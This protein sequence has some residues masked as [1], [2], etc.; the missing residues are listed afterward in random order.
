MAINVLFGGQAF[1]TPVSDS[2]YSPCVDFYQYVNG[3]LKEAS[4]D[5]TGALKEIKKKTKERLTALFEEARTGRHT[6][7]DTT[8]LLLGRFYSSCMNAVRDASDSAKRAEACQAM[9]NNLLGE[10]VGRMYVSKT[11]PPESKKRAFIMVNNIKA[12]MRKRLERVAW[13]SPATKAKALA[14]LD[15]MQVKVGY[16]DRWQSYSGL[17]LEDTSEGSFARNLVAINQFNRKNQLY[18]SQSSDSGGVADSSAW[19]RSVIVVNAY[20]SMDKNQIIIPAA[21]L[22]PPLFDPNADDASNYGAIGAV[23]GHEIVHAF[24]VR[25]RRYDEHGNKTDWW[26]IADSLR[27]IEQSEKLADQYSSYIAIDDLRVDGRRTIGENIADLGGVRAAYDALQLALSNKFKNKTRPKIHGL[28]PE[29]RF[30]IAYARM[31][32]DTRSDDLLRDQVFG[33][34]HAPSR[35]RVNGVLVN[36]PEFAK[37]FDCNSEDRMAK[38]EGNMVELW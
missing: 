34:M 35:W 31:W 1:S 38:P 30:F 11:F 6:T 21:V 20:Y 3:E 29:Q 28:T 37:A 18:G 27:F 25:G 4:P 10:L 5:N 33:D 15:G 9:A 17:V 22:Q 16:P 32:R 8:T 2:V 19:N 7:S 23:I 13:L 26:S 14:K 36:I 24:D 12:A